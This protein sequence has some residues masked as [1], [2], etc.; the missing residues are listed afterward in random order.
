MREY[1]Q[2]LYGRTG[3]HTKKEKTLL[4]NISRLKGI[5][6][7]SLYVYIPQLAVVNC[8]RMMAHMCMFL[9]SI[10]PNTSILC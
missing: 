3:P 2:E 4:K 7:H 10:L 5:Q 9:L 1:Q 8:Q 6:I